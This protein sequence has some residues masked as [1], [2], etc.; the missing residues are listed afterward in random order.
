[1][2]L[3]TAREVLPCVDP[4]GRPSRTRLPAQAS[5]PVATPPV[6]AGNQTGA[7]FGVKAGETAALL[8]RR[9]HNR[10]T[11]GKP[12]G[13]VGYSRQHGRLCFRYV[14]T[15]PA[16]VIHFCCLRLLVGSSHLDTS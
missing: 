7:R 16:G 5:P 12:A 6:C 2:L 1:M 8:D 3:L 14:E 9:Q 10:S 15:P 13:E 11:N 4:M